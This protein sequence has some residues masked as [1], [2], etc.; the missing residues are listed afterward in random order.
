MPASGSSVAD[1][2]ARLSILMPCSKKTAAATITMAEL[3]IQPRPMASD[4]SP[5]SNWISLRRPSSSSGWSPV[6]HH[7]RMQVDV[8]GHDDGPEHADGHQQAGAVE[9]RDDSVPERPR[10]NRDPREPAR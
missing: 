1:A 4:V 5:N 10:P 7:V 2:W 3:I 9:T 6:E 8:V